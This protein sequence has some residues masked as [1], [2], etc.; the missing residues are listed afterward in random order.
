MR[1]LA[2][3]VDEGIVDRPRFLPPQFADINA[4]AAWMCYSRFLNRLTLD[5]MEADY[6]GLL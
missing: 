6:G 4:I 3:L 2:S 1:A 5:R